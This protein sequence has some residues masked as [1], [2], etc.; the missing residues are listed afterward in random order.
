MPTQTEQWIKL[1]L[2]YMIKKS[3]YLI[4]DHTALKKKKKTQLKCGLLY[5]VFHESYPQAQSCDLLCCDQP[6]LGEVGE[7]AGERWS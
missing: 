5:S 7:S 2:N 6:G 3:L 4:K 1:S